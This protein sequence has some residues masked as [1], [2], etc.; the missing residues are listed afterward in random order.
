MRRQPK[1]YSARTKKRILPLFIVFL[2]SFQQLNMADIF[3]SI[4][5]KAQESLLSI[6]TDSIYEGDEAALILKRSTEGAE[7]IEFTLPDGI[8]I[9]IDK[10][11]ENFSDTTEFNFD[12]DNNRVKVSYAEGGSDN[13]V[14]I[15]ILFEVAGTYEITATSTSGDSSKLNLIVNEAM[16]EEQTEKKEEETA[17]EGTQED[18]VNVELQTQREAIE[19]KEMDGPIHRS[20]AERVTTWDEFIA[21][22]KNTEVSV[23]EIQANLTRTA[24]GTQYNPGS[25]ARNLTINGNGHVIDFGSGGTSSNGIILDAVSESTNLV[26]NDVYFSKTQT[27]GTPIFNQKNTAASTNWHII[28]NNVNSAEDNLAGLVTAEN[29]TVTVYG[30]NNLAL[31]GS[32]Y[33]FYVS[34]FEMTE[35][36][37]LTATSSGTSYAVIRIASGEVN[38]RADSSLKIVNTG[39]RTTA[40]GTNTANYSHGL[41][42]SISSLNL[43]SNSLLDIDVTNTG[44]RTNVVN[45]LTMVNGAVFNSKARVQSAVVLAENYGDGAGNTATV[46]LDGEGTQLNIETESKDR[47]QHGAAMRVAGSNSTLDVQN[48]AEVKSYSKYGTGLQFQGSDTVFNVKSGSKINIVQEGDNGYS[49]GAALRF[50]LSGN[51]TF[52]V[53]NAEINITKLSGDAPAVRLYGGN[54]A[55]NVTNGGKFVVHNTGNGSPNNGTGDRGNQ[56]ILYTNGNSDSFNLDGFGSTVEITADNGPA[57]RTNGRSAVTGGEGTI[58]NLEGKT[59]GDNYGILSSSSAIDITIDNP[60]YFDFRNNRSGGGNVFRTGSSSSSFVS[61]NSD[62]SVWTKGSNLDGTPTA[63]W[64]KFDYSLTGSNF[65]E[66][67][68]TNIPETFNE[69]TYLGADNYSRMSANNATAVIDELRVPTDADK[70]IYGHASVP[71]GVTGSRDAWTDEVCVTVRVKNA[72]GTTAYE[73]E[74]TTVGKDD[75]SDGLSVYGE[76]ERAGIF[77]ILNDPDGDGVGQYLEAGQTVEVVSAYRSSGLASLVDGDRVHYSSEDDIITSTVTTRDV[78]PPSAVVLDESSQSINTFT[79]EIS[80]TNAE[81]G[82]TIRVK[83]NDEWVTDGTGAIQTATVDADGKWSFSLPTLAEGD[84]VAIYASDNTPESEWDDILN[85]PIT[86]GEFGNINPDEDMDY[87]DATFPARV[88]LTVIY[89]GKLSLVAPDNISFGDN[90]EI[91]PQDTLY[92]IETADNALEVIDTRSTKSAWK[93][94]AELINELHNDT[95][96]STLS[97]LYV[98]GGNEAVLSTDAQVPIYEHTNTANDT[99]SIIDTWYGESGDGLYVQANSGQAR[100]GEYTGAI[101]WT[102]ADTPANE[103]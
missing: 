67:E 94:T 92:Q 75:N 43:E 17:D 64:T 38:L 51:Q 50:R 61:T 18:A 52:N 86:S 99:F 2:L 48:G 40:D 12:E 28:L 73:L 27:P 77:V 20:E 46:K 76:D 93:L 19:K 15:H 66:I 78:T 60:L 29:A 37:A 23:I 54:N 1:P 62:L 91:S 7:V 89:T 32:S 6:D 80:G 13:L 33:Q 16:N 44:Y 84:V 10:T 85:P 47:A 101:K 25:I 74:G 24:T 36:A 34:N 57:I 14:K 96:D 100:V 45:S 21:A 82:A 39:T 3:G 98:K 30:E 49:L 35:G 70:Y 4:H 26:L 103:E 22:L 5:A 83:V 68:S 88:A 72:D 63:S 56:G 31:S 59:A 55:I 97:L 87:H 65:K 69:T 95:Y 11:E 42:G 9:D 71:E 90:V 58:F 41:Y 102:L 53:N 79:K 8:A 81:I